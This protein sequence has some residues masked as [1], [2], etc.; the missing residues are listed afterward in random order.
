MFKYF[1]KGKLLK[2]MKI[3]TTTQ[4][5]KDGLIIDEI[6]S[7]PSEI[8]NVNGG[9]QNYNLVDI[10]G[11]YH[12]FFHPYS[13]KTIP[14]F[15]KI[16]DNGYCY[17]Y[18]EIIFT[19]NKEIVIDHTSLRNHPMI[20][21][22]T[23]NKIKKIYY[24]LKYAKSYIKFYLQTFRAKKINGSCLCLSRNGL[25]KNY[26]H[27]L[28]ECM[29]NYHLVKEKIADIDFIIV[30]HSL[31]FQQEIIELL[32]I[33]KEK[34]ISVDDRY[35][36]QA[37]KLIVPTILADWEY[38]DLRHHLHYG[39][40]GT[41]SKLTSFYRNNPNICNFDKKQT[42]KLFISRKNASFRF[43]ENNDNVENLFREFGYKIIDDKSIP[44]KE[45]IALCNQS[46]VI[47]GIHG[48]GLTN[49]L[50]APKKS[51]LF[52]LE[53]Q[54]FHDNYFVTLA[55]SLDIN[56]HYIVGETKDTSVHPRL[57]NAY[58]DEAKLK[59]ALNILEEKIK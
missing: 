55:N 39:S 36:L 1:A 32:E 37:K 26:G 27:F 25:E 47:A 18:D 52:V 38:I 40:L 2:I 17:N 3:T 10:F 6:L 59:E 15:I 57:E 49:I 33:P 19:K 12:K 50:F 58:F 31:K 44:L 41:S 7:I 5:K 23:N 9:G 28:I 43:I 34:L 29:A 35:L 54:Y 24:K 16:L 30:D 22:A 14:L 8:V 21:P 46:K 48:A 20:P 11:S 51:H 53:T 42:L 4:A 45:L 56:Y 13:H